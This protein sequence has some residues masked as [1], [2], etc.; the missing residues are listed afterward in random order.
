MQVSV[1]FDGSTARTPQLIAAELVR[2]GGTVLW[3]EMCSTP[4]YTEQMY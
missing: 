3:Y 4:V 1:A 2:L